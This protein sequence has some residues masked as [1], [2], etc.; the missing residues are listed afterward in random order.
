MDRQAII[1]TLIKMAIHNNPSK[2]ITKTEIQE[3]R[4]Y[5][6]TKTDVQLANILVING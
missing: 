3:Y 5:L 2:T 6:N 1:E 4:E